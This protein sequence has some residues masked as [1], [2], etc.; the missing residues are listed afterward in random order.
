VVHR[1]AQKASLVVLPRRCW[2][3]E[4]TFAQ[5]ASADGSPATMKNCRDHL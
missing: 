1:L 2:V 3:V 4:R 5:R